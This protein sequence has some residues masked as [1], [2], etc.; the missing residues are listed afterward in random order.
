MIVFE[1]LGNAG[2]TIDGHEPDSVTDI[3][4]SFRVVCLNNGNDFI[5]IGKTND[6][7][8]TL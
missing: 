3:K 7:F 6:Q 1:L 4:R 2:L 5:A 8:F